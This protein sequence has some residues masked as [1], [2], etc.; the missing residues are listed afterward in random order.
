MSEQWQNINERLAAAA[1]QQRQRSKA[2]RDLKS[3]EADLAEETGRLETLNQRLG[4]EQ[5][6]VE[7]LEH[8]S[9]ATLFYSV[10]G[11][12]DTQLEKE[13]QE[14]LQAQLHAETA[15][16]AI[17]SL[18]AEQER[19]KELLFR[20]RGTEREYAAAL[21]EKE[22]LI[23]RENPLISG[24]IAALDQQVM[25]LQAELKEINEAG[26]AGAQAV[27]GLSR[28][29]ASL[30]SAENWG[31]WDIMGGGILST[32]IKHSR[33]DDARSGVHEVQALISRFKRELADV[34]RTAALDVPIGE[35]ATFADYFFDG[36]IVD[37]VVQSKIETSLNQAY[38]TQK[39]IQGAL[40]Q[41]K[42]LKRQTEEQIRAAQNRRGTLLETPIH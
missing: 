9:L 5:R 37:W 38:D 30:Q 25:D 36:L 24:E 21:A 17:A 12:R 10:L 22:E 39:A 1:E 8:A 2:E 42:K 29:I 31:V 41:L 4:K 27:D 26:S 3:V 13:R 14:L 34:G 33:I 32:A 20:L 35:F 6:D 23:R 11:S 16:R 18:Q 40:D 28:V 15:R 19:L 7:R